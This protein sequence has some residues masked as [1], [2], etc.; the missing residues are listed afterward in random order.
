M[1][2]EI[3]RFE[4]LKNIEKIL[5]VIGRGYLLCNGDKFGNNVICR[6]VEIIKGI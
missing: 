4:V 6:Y 5:K 3:L 2:I 1:K